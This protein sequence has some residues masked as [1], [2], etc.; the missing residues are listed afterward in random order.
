MLERIKIQLF[1]P[2]TVWLILIIVAI[3]ASLQRL[4]LPMKMIGGQI[5]THFNNFIIFKNA[6][7][8]LFN[9]Q[10]LYLNYNTEQYDLFKYTP[11]FALFFTFFTWFDNWIGLNLWNILN[12]TVLF[13]GIYA[14]PIEK[15]STKAKIAFFILIE[16]ITSLQNQQTNALNVGLILLFF[17]NMEKKNY[18]IGIFFIVLAFYSKMYPIAVGAIWFFY[19]NKF[20]NILYGLFWLAV[21][22]L[23]PA[24][25]VGFDGLIW[26]Y[27]N[28][29]E[30]I[31]ADHEISYGL[32]LLNFI[33]KTTGY[34]C[35]KIGLAVFGFLMTISPL[36]WVKRYQNTTYRLVFLGA[37]MIF[38]IVFNHKSE[39]P[40]FILAAVGVALWYFS[41]PYNKLNF[42]LLVFVFLFSWLAPTDLWPKYVR[43][44]FFEAYCFKVFP[45]FVIWLKAL[46]DMH[47]KIG[48]T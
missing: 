2:L 25:F 24:L 39:S 9:H 42:A 28:Y 30:M 17:A 46:Y 18:F 32:S 38:M 40:T 1:K 35:N 5:A 44:N 27:R 11:T 47:Y 3:I 15:N 8:H 43:I 33:L 19:D 31:K 13:L 12:A 36:L 6:S 34:E 16:L 20:K 4:M 23:L 7:Y 22:G 14:L 45:C 21:L 10:N 29:L 37:F 48:K 41:Q 26:Q